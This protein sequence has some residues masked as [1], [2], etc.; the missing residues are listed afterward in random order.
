VSQYT[1][2]EAMLRK[3]NQK[4]SLDNIVIQK[5]QFDWSSFFGGDDNDTTLAQALEEFDDTVDAQAAV[6]AT[7]EAD[8]LEHADQADFDDNENPADPALNEDGKAS[9]SRREEDVNDS[10]AVGD[11]DAEQVE[12][13][14]EDEGETVVEYM[15]SFVKDDWGFFQ[16]W[17]V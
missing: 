13:D 1:V 11:G 6:A 17:R 5:G 7:K 2:E 9:K 4:R 16:D 8:I 3:A 10:A 15:L 14:E 12:E